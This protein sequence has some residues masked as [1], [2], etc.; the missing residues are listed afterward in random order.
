LDAVEL[1]Y[2]PQNGATTWPPFWGPCVG[3]LTNL[4]PKNGTCFGAEIA[5]VCKK[6][7]KAFWRWSN[8]LHSRVPVGE[9]AAVVNIDETSIRLY[10]NSGPGFIVDIA[11]RQKRSNKSLCRDV[12]KGQLRGSFTLIAM[13]TSYLP[14]QKHLPQM[15]F[16]NAAHIGSD[17]FDNIVKDMLPTVHV[18]RVKN[19]WTTVEKMKQ[20]LGLLKSVVKEKT[21]QVRIL[22]CADTYKAHISTAI[23]MCAA[24]HGI[25]YFTVP[26]K[27]TWAL[28][29]CDTH[30]FATFKHHLAVASQ[31][32]TLET[33]GGKL[34]VT[35]LLKAL[36]LTVNCVLNEKDWSKAFADVGLTDEQTRVSKSL[37]EILGFDVPPTIAKLIPTLP[38]L[39]ACFPKGWDIAIGWVFAATVQAAKTEQPSSPGHDVNSRS[40]SSAQ[41]S[42][43]ASGIASCV[44]PSAS[45]SSHCAKAQPCP[46]AVRLVPPQQLLPPV[47]PVHPKVHMPLSPPP[48]PKVPRLHRLPSWTPKPKQP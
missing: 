10:Q 17:D 30:V 25:F 39:Q 26:P 32:M 38:E 22:L 7:A 3:F 5:T 24:K 41:P 34:T 20:M 23:F 47:H 8:F 11:R 16:I 12:T 18:Y 2:E 35:N 14:L 46:R 45:S 31:K 33:C 9:T 36:N 27:M 6:K 44:A 37:L 28:Q 42:P 19:S 4:Q 13:V 29:P 48:T 21:P 40:A 1:K 15:A 43:L